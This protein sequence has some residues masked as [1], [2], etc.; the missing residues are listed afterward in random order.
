MNRSIPMSVAILLF[1]G[2]SSLPRITFPDSK[3]E[4]HAQS[5][6]APM[7]QLGAALPAMKPSDERD[8][9]IIAADQ[10]TQQGYFV[11]AIELYREAETMAP[12]KSKLDAKLAPAF[13]GAGRYTESLERYRRVIESDPKNASLIN[14]FAFTLMESGDESTAEAEFKH[15]LEIDPHL[16]NASVNL[17]LLLARQR[18]EE[19][20]IAVLTPA[21]GIAAAHHNLGVIAIE[22][23]D[24][25]S[26][27]QH[28]A[29]AASCPAAPKAT[30]EFIAAL[31][32]ERR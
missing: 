25:A 19:E 22:L 21:I 31:S 9:K 3:V 30:D 10:M 13:A 28:F 7:S 26:A 11:D 16:E 23:D 15:A 20:A 12:K 32:R 5:S 14:N 17:G 6:E 29:N 27:N 4:K 1:S 24:E 18:R 8:L 2:C